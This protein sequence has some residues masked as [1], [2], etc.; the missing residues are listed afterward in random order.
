MEFFPAGER[1]SEQLRPVPRRQGHFGSA[2]RQLGPDP[3]PAAD[4][5][6]GDPA[7]PEQEPEEQDDRRHRQEDTQPH[8]PAQPV[9]GRTG[10]AHIGQPGHALNGRADGLGTGKRIKTKKSILCHTNRA[11]DCDIKL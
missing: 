2:H 7:R 10:V 6:T 8:V 5:R 3:H 9:G 4:G 1:T 11:L